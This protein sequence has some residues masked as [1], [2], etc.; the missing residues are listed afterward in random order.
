MA[1]TSACATDVMAF[2]PVS[3]EVREAMMLA[4]TGT[5]Q[6]AAIECAEI[7]LQRLQ[8]LHDEMLRRFDEAQ[9]QA[10]AQRLAV[11]KNFDDTTLQAQPIDFLPV[12]HDDDKS[13]KITA[14]IFSLS[15]VSGDTVD[16]WYGGNCDDQ[17]SL[18]EV[19]NQEVGQEVSDCNS[20][21]DKE[22]TKT[23]YC[24]A[25]LPC[26]SVFS[27]SELGLL[28]VDTVDFV[29]DED[30]KCDSKGDIKHTDD[31]A[32]VFFESE[33][34][35]MA[36]I[37]ADLEL[38]EAHVLHSKD[39]GNS[40]GEVDK[41][42]VESPVE[43]AQCA[44]LDSPQSATSKAVV[45][46]VTSMQELVWLRA[47]LKQARTGWSAKDL[48]QVEDKLRVVGV[49]SPSSLSEVLDSNQLNRRL[50]RKDLRCL[51]SATLEALRDSVT[52]WQEDFYSH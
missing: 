16:D 21:E 28:D 36:D 31:P 9:R 7:C 51:S 47:V 4:M 5:L 41:V 32:I 14:P 1:E 50:R 2:D 39:P 22:N 33:D 30:G 35:Y 49:H 37:S 6:H 27:S 52:E 48:R 26:M 23:S 46:P 8:V 20:T 17:C 11:L 25:A 10:S 38:L 43:V 29:D 44:K 40:R 3:E 13:P 45:N 15:D 42:E 34:S 24:L 18:V 12:P 19:D